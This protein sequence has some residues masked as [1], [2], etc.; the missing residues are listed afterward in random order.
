LTLLETTKLKALYTVTYE[1]IFPHNLLHIRSISYHR[2]ISYNQA[3]MDSFSAK[4]KTI[5]SK[6]IFKGNY[7]LRTFD[8]LRFKKPE[9]LRN[10]GIS[11]IVTGRYNKASSVYEKLIKIEPENQEAVIKLAYVYAE[12]GKFNAAIDSA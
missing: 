4:E 10:L 1:T 3:A 9:V 12:Q 6:R 11:Y 2:R 8:K 5:T 7:I